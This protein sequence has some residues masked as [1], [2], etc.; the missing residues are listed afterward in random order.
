MFW[1]AI[2]VVVRGFISF[3]VR[4]A[5]FFSLQPP[6][7]VLFFFIIILLF[8]A[9]QRRAA[10]VFLSRSAWRGWRD[11]VVCAISPDGRPLGAGGAHVFVS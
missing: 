11:G 10:V 4:G 8:T 1:R 6:N 7:G 9:R 2:A 5:C 3:F